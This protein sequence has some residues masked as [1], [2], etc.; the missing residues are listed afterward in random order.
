MGWKPWV[1]LVEIVL[2]NLAW[3]DALDIEGFLLGS[4]LGI[5]AGAAIWI[6]AGSTWLVVAGSLYLGLLAAMKVVANRGRDDGEPTDQG[7]SRR[8]SSR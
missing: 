7:A 4:A 1:G 6:F 8:S 2:A 5:G 3:I